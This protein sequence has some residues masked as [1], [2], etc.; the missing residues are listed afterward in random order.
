MEGQHSWVDD[1]FSF[2]GSQSS[3][4]T[5][6]VSGFLQTIFVDELRIMD[7]AKGESEGIFSLR[8][9]N[10]YVYYVSYGHSYG[11]HHEVIPFL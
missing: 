1:A 8:L 3:F 10:A 9:R 7:I 2:R 5:A 6:A 11:F 4:S